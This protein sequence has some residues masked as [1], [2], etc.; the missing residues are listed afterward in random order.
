MVKVRE[1]KVM[2]FQEKNLNDIPLGLSMME[3]LAETGFR[4]NRLYHS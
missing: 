1:G 3:K 4:Q 2:E